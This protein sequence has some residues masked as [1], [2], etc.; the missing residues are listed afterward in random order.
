MSAYAS[1]GLSGASVSLGVVNSRTISSLVEEVETI[2]NTIP[3]V[4]EPVE[5]VTT[6]VPEADKDLEE[7][8]NSATELE[9]VTKRLASIETSL[10][11]LNE[12]KG[13]FDTLQLEKEKLSTN[14]RNLDVE[15]KDTL[16]D[17]ENLVALTPE[18]RDV[19]DNWKTLKTKASMDEDGE[20]L[21]ISQC[22][23]GLLKNQGDK[24]ALHLDGVD[25]P[26]WTMY[27]SNTSGSDPS[28]NKPVSHAQ[29]KG[30][31]LRMVV[32]PGPNEGL[33]VERAGAELG[34]TGVFSVG[35][36][37]IV[38]AGSATISDF[39]PD[40]AGFAHSNQMGHNKMA[41]LQ[42]NSGMTT[43]NSSPG[44]DLHLCIN[45][46]PKVR[47]D[48]SSK[49]TMGIKNGANA[50]DTFF[51]LDGD[52]IITTRDGAYTRFRSGTSEVDHVMVN[53][54]GVNVNGILEVGG[55]NVSQ[56]I[57]SAYTRIQ[58]IETKLELE[59]D[60]AIND[61][62]NPEITDGFI[63]MEDAPGHLGPPV[64]KVTGPAGTYSMVRIF[65]KGFGTALSMAQVEVFNHDLSNIA[66]D[67]SKVHG[68]WQTDVVSGGVASRAVDGDIK[69]NWSGGGVMSTTT[70][71]RRNWRIAFNKQ[72][73]I[74]AIRIYNRTDSCCM[75][76]LN[77]A[78]LEL[79]SNGKVVAVHTL[80]GD[81]KQTLYLH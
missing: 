22:N 14:F 20:T 59:A 63:E 35:G 10:I 27:M 41:V 36:T 23:L 30:N 76:R 37:G 58:S 29:V 67:P 39:I 8:D 38:T 72:E 48:P 52:N 81:A 70:K 77:G 13:P 7:L 2:K 21:R 1:L 49:N 28:G 34:A 6:N 56:R 66:R 42:T 15:I 79:V 16:L 64:P 47:I 3:P 75:D 4:N 32:G 69:G 54:T 68:V 73:A 50:S 45:G 18:I 9:N 24:S 62:A 61:L 12:T 78:T 43:L 60:S 5:P 46:E 80:N 53:N 25:N 51:N 31:A 65:N 57:E 19:L 71:A 17:I 26:L 11:N 44:S 74:K 33:V 55:N 40:S